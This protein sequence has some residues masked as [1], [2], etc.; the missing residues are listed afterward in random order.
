[1][2]KVTIETENGEQIIRKGELLMC[3]MLTKTEAGY[4]AESVLMGKVEADMLPRIVAETAAARIVKTREGDVLE[5]AE[6]LIR[7]HEHI[8]KTVKQQLAEKGDDL[9]R[10]I[11]ECLK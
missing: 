1:M 11:G 8:E 9:L 5:M 3:D 4:E 6:G 2:V 7:L 10:C